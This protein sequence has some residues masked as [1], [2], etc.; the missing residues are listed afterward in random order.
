MKEDI[1]SILNESLK[2]G[3]IGIGV[4]IV[5]FISFTGQMNLSGSTLVI[6]FFLYLL[7]GYV[8]GVMIPFSESLFHLLLVKFFPHLKRY[9][10]LELIVVFIIGSTTF[11][12]CFNLFILII[13]I[14]VS[15]RIE[16]MFYISI[17]VGVVSVMISLFYNYSDQLEE[18]VEL[19]KEN[20]KLAVVEERNRIAR[21]LHDSVS[22]NLFGIS[23]NLTTLPSIIE[24]DKER[25]IMMT[26]QLENMVQE[27]QTEMRLMI[28]ELRPLNFRDREF[29]ESIDSLISLF[30]KRY[31]VDIACN[32]LGDE[33]ELEES[34]QLALYRI[35][36]EALNNTIKHA[37]ASRIKVALHIKDNSARLTVED[38]GKGFDTGKK[39]KTDHYGI[40]SMRERLEEIG[41][42]L[43]I[44]SNI[45]EGTAVIADV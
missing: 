12:L 29:F 11:Y 25:A 27:V 21:E 19:E 4:S 42:V 45:G 5:F 28:Y 34:K 35:L 40:K 44:K 9:L 18:K 36:Q 13:N 3:I 23:L 24:E 16:Y 37:D 26:E 41:G 6:A 8:V 14:F 33:V 39:I 10:L 43:K 22:Q 32:L 1:I 15:S 38:D 20:R 7:F 31:R 2:A 30:R 17:G